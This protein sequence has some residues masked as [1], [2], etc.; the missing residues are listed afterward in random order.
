ME[1]LYIHRLTRLGRLSPN[2]SF[3]PSGVQEMLPY[4][5][6]PCPLLCTEYL[7]FSYLLMVKQYDGSI[8]LLLE[9]VINTRIHSTNTQCE[10]TTCKDLPTARDT[11][12]AKKPIS[13]NKL[14]ASGVQHIKAKVETHVRCHYSRKSWNQPRGNRS[15][16]STA[17][18]FVPQ[19]FLTPLHYTSG[20]PKLN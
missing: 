2:L 1:E 4:I 10:P 5:E 7:K 13:F 15:V 9:H 16:F 17:L 12:L 19:S 20:I 6:L 8:L 11:E 18:I 14:T 3:L